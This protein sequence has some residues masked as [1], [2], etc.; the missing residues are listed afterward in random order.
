MLYY[1]TV[2]Y[3]LLMKLLN[4]EIRYKER[5]KG[6]ISDDLASCLVSLSSKVS[7]IDFSS[8]QQHTNI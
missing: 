2:L 7:F 1:T 3:S 5:R 6:F 4:I 8:I